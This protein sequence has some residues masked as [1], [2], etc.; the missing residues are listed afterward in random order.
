[1]DIQ[2]FTTNFELIESRTVAHLKGQY[3]CFMATEELPVHKSV[4]TGVEFFVV[5]DR[6][7]HSVAQY[8]MPAAAIFIQRAFAMSMMV[9][10]LDAILLHEQAHGDLGHLDQMEELRKLKESLPFAT[11]QLLVSTLSHQQE[12]EADRASLTHGLGEQLITGLYK[13]SCGIDG[14]SDTHPCNQDRANA[15]GLDY[16]IVVA[17]IELPVEEW[18]EEEEE[19]FSR[20]FRLDVQWREIRDRLMILAESWNNAMTV[21]E[22]Q[23]EK[24][25]GCLY[26][27]LVDAINWIASMQSRYRRLHTWAKKTDRLPSDSRLDPMDDLTDRAATLKFDEIKGRD[28]HTGAKECPC[29]NCEEPF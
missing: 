27:D 20:P 23:F 2:E 28:Y 18:E 8:E 22:E 9:E 3:F 16:E 21:Y 10:E 12:F 5:D 4:R 25:D 14:G 24:Y 17:N 19:D 15:L 29:L 6:R 11:F 26:P 1:M 13:L 7:P